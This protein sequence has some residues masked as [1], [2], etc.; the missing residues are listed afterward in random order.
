MLLVFFGDHRPSLPTAYEQTIYQ[1]LG[2][3]DNSVDYYWTPEQRAVLFSTDY[4]AWSNRGAL[5]TALFGE[6]VLSGDMLIGSDILDWAGV[7]QT[8]FWQLIGQLGD[9]VAS[10]TEN[11]FVAADGTPS[12]EPAAECAGIIGRVEAVMYDAFFG[13]RYITDA[14]NA[15]R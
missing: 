2:L 4:L 13:E 11:G 10:Y 5:D 9:S 3:C 6:D 8:L 12:A 1:K 15:Y 7:R 14:L